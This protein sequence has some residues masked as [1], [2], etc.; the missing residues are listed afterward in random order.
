M[1]VVEGSRQMALLILDD[2]RR[3][4]FG[5]IGRKQDQMYEV[6]EE[7]DGTLILTPVVVMSA[8]ERDLLTGPPELRAALEDTLAGRNVSQRPGLRRRA[9]TSSSD[10]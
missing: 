9:R 8:A 4:A 2:R 1:V 6:S 5:R 10:R 7:P 3:A